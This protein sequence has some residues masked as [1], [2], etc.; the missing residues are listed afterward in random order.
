MAVAGVIWVPGEFNI[1][2]SPADYAAELET[3]AKSLPLTYGQEKVPFFYAQPSNTL[4]KGI[5]APSIPGAKC[6]I[7]EKWPKSLSEIADQLG[8]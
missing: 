7:F 2:H 8:K 3:Y 4:L 5:S 6:V 1:G